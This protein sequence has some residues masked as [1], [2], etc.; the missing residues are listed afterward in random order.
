MRLLA[1]SL[2]YSGDPNLL[3]AGLQGGF[4]TIVDYLWNE[5]LSHQSPDMAKLMSATALANCFCAS[6][7]DAL[8]EAD[9]QP[10]GDKMNGD[11]FI[12]RLQKENLFLVPLDTVNQ[13]FRYHPM[14]RQLLKKQVAKWWP[15]E[16]IAAL[17]SRAN[18]WFE[19]NRITGA[20]LIESPA[21]LQDSEYNA[22]SDTTVVI[23][24]PPHGS[25]FPSAAH[26]PMVEPLTNR[27]LDV[28][29]LLVQRLSNKEIADQLCISTTTVKGHLQNIYG[30]LSVNKR[31]EAIELAKK[32]G[33]I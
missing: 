22:V 6:L 21:S 23:T 16:G 32:M 15:P 3:L 31:R 18:A 20:G 24:P 30:K 4:A 9:P 27:E 28:L 12:A 13:W 26:P 7:C 8:M 19:K 2:K 14:F 33:I 11:E 5:V 1:Q 25:P 10:N 17:H 29:S